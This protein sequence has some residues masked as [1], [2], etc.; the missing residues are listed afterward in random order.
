MLF[1]TFGSV[2][3][4]HTILLPACRQAGSCELD[5][6]KRRRP[7]KHCGFRGWGL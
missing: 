7:G 1:E 4:V 5:H 6:T 3:I 2:N